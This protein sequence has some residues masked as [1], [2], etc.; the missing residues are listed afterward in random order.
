MI[1]HKMGDIRVILGYTYITAD[2]KRFFEKTSL[3]PVK[4][5][6][7]GDKES[8][9]DGLIINVPYSEILERIDELY[10]QERLIKNVAVTESGFIADD[11]CDL[12]LGMA[13][14]FA[15]QDAEHDKGTNI[16]G[17]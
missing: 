6:V 16:P 4:I 5:M 1:R 14:W 7:T 11:D 8:Y 10:E 12:A 15:A 3:K 13:V 17:F 2:M 9:R